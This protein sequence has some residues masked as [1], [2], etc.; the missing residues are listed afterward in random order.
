MTK[1]F[2]YTLL[3][4]LVLQVTLRV[5]SEQCPYGR[6]ASYVEHIGDQICRYRHEQGHWPKDAAEISAQG[7]PGNGKALETLYGV[8]LN[9][10]PIDC[11]LTAECPH[12]GIPLLSWIKFAGYFSGCKSHGISL[13]NRYEQLYG[14]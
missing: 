7:I 14:N 10:D 9:Y 4:F 8:P 3:I 2:I 11:S 12:N 5:I 1:A 6:C 13:T